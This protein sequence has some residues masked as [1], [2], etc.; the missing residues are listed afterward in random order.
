[1]KRVY[2]MILIVTLV[3]LFM[4]GTII[5]KPSIHTAT[6]EELTEIHG[7]GDILADRVFS[8]LVVNPESNIEDL[9]DIEGIGKERLRLIKKEFR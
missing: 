6:I 4:L 1:M 3:V 8:Y 9:V 5:Y 2:M 7:I